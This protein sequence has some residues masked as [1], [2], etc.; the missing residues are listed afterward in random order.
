MDKQLKRNQVTWKYYFSNFTIL[1][2]GW[3]ITSDV[4]QSSFIGNISFLGGANDS[5]SESITSFE[6]TPCGVVGFVSENLSIK[7][8]HKKHVNLEQNKYIL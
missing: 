1:L 5:Q 8:Y 3:T 4:P 7:S 2:T 6:F